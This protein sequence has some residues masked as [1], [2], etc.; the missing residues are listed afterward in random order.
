MVNSIVSA[1]MD[2]TQSS[3]L[4]VLQRSFICPLQRSESRG[5]FDVKGS[6]SYYRFL[7]LSILS[8]PVFPRLGHARLLIPEPTAVGGVGGGGKVRSPGRQRC[9]HRVNVCSVLPA[10]PSS[11]DDADH[12]EIMDETWHGSKPGSI[13]FLGKS[14]GGESR[15]GD[16]ESVGVGC[17]SGK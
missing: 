2:L 12:K 8:R 10:S 5:D 14:G 1:T 15:R 6:L 7:F 11:G 9:A 4:H 13:L 3:D 16:A 17:R